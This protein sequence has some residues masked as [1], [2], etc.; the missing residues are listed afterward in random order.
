MKAKFKLKVF[1]ITKEESKILKKAFIEAMR[2]IQY[3]RRQNGKDLLSYEY[4]FKD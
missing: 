3:E 4:R 1:G 2:K